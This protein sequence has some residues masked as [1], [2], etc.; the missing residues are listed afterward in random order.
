MPYLVLVLERNDAKAVS[1]RAVLRQLRDGCALT[2]SPPNGVV[3]SHLGRIDG[4]RANLAF[5]FQDLEILLGPLPLRE[6]LVSP[7]LDEL[8]G[9]GRRAL[10]LRDALAD[11][12]YLI[13]E[14]ESLLLVILQAALHHLELGTHCSLLTKIAHGRRPLVESLEAL[15][16]LLG[17]R[18][19]SA[20]LEL[21]LLKTLAALF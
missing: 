16:L 11:P 20:L 15:A 17:R 14:R 4:A 6:E 12:P 18:L 5:A 3:D 21:H 19:Q 13:E 1:A 8:A 7:R 9:F 10:E 2:L